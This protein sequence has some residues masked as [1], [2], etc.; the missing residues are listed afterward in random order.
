MNPKYKTIGLPIIGPIE[1][2]AIV[3]IPLLH[4]ELDSQRQ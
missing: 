1:D 3:Q 2:G 4:L